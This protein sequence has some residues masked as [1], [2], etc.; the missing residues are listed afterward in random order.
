[1]LLPPTPPFSFPHLLFWLTFILVNQEAYTHM[2]FPEVAEVLS[3]C[4]FQ[5]SVGCLVFL[6]YNIFPLIFII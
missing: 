1:M 4:H 3:D 6:P 5:W 2:Q